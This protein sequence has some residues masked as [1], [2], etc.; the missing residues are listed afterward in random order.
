MCEIKYLLLFFATIRLAAKILRKSTHTLD[1]MSVVK[2]E[3]RGKS[4]EIGI[5]LFIKLG[6]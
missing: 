3:K 2:E 4:K 5:S 1:F 6:A